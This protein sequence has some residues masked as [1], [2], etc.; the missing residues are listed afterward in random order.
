MPVPIRTSVALLLFVAVS[1]IAGGYGILNDPS[2]GFLKMSTRDLAGS[3]F[4]TF[5][6]PGLFL[7]VVLGFG[8][9]AAAVL[10]RKIPGRVSW[11]FAVGIST[12]LLAWL[13]VQVAIV[14]YR[15]LLQVLYASVGVILLALLT[16]RTA[17]EYRCAAEPGRPTYR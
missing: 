16:G 15:G 5:L 10:L 8:S 12:V 13:A 4:L 14:G 6:I 2:G 3:P 7:L 17:R 11:F 9:A 1:A